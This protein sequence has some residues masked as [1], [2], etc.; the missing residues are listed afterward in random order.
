MQNTLSAAQE[1]SA[2]GIACPLWRNDC[3]T[4]REERTSLT[5]GRDTT[6]PSGW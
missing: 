3:K 6:A 2:C 5:A 4:V 1:I